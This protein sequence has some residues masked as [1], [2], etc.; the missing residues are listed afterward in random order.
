MISDENG[1]GNNPIDWG[2]PEVGEI[3]ERLRDYDFDRYVYIGENGEIEVRN[4]EIEFPESEELSQQVFLCVHLTNLRQIMDKICYN[5]LELLASPIEDDSNPEENNLE[6]YRTWISRLNTIESKYLL[7]ESYMETGEFDMKDAKME[8]IQI[9]LISADGTPVYG[10]ESFGIFENYRR[11]FQ[12]SQEYYQL[13]LEHGDSDFE[14]PSHIIEQFRDL[15]N[16]DNIVG[17]KSA[18][19]LEKYSIEAIDYRIPD[20]RDYHI[21]PAC[22]AMVIGLHKNASEDS[23]LYEEPEDLTNKDNIEV[24]VHPNPTN[25]TI[26]ISLD[27]M[28]ETSIHYQ[29]Y[30]IQ[31]KELQSG[32]F[33]NQKQELDISSLSK[34]LY[35]I[36]VTVENQ[37][38][39]TKKIVKE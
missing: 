34:G 15:S 20:V 32:N 37:S 29:I 16:F 8:E 12:V 14:I 39:I 33:S 23:P 4:I 35:F 38:K 1:F 21:H 17:I 19:F 6:Q 2:N 18:S 30:D 5:A 9:S 28:S 3:L 24:N 25:N 22:I 31:G 11:Y 27:K 7:A 10:E 26:F 36:S 13:A